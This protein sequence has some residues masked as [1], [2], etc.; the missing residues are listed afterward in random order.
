MHTKP[1][2]VPTPG[3]LCTANDPD[4]MEYRYAEHI[5]YCRHSLTFALQATVFNRYNIRLADRNKY[6]IDYLIPTACGLSNSLD[7]LWPQ[8]IAEA[9]EK[10][11]LEDI[12]YRL[13]QAGSISQAEIVREI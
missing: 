7:N 9:A 1:N 13:L 5:P 12:L 10:N 3:C 6:E 11:K 8:P 4:F 2:P